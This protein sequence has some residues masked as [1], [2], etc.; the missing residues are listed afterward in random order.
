MKPITTISEGRELPLYMLVRLSTGEK[1]R[2]RVI[3]NTT[4]LPNPGPDEQFL[5]MVQDDVPPFDPD[6]QTIEPVEGPNDQTGQWE[7]TYIVSDKPKEELLKAAEHAARKQ[8]PNVVP[9]QD[10]TETAVI[11]LAALIRAGKFSLTPEEQVFADAVT[12]QAEK[13]LKNRLNLDAIKAEIEKGNKPDLKTG[14]EAATVSAV[15]IGITAEP[16]VP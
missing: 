13:L 6:L 16:L 2:E 3:S 11:A 5:A 1:I 12:A 9:P 4:G 15:G 14:W 8:V 7:I 10:F